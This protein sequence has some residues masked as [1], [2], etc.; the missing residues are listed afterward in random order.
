MPQ[1][2]AKTD[3]LEEMVEGPARDSLALSSPAPALR[4]A[5]EEVPPGSSAALAP[6]NSSL[7]G[8][9]AKDEMIA[10][11]KKQTESVLAQ[12]R[13]ATERFREVDRFDA[14]Q[15][16]PAPVAAS[17]AAL[18]EQARDFRAKLG[19]EVTFYECGA[20]TATAEALVTADQITRDLKEKNAP[21]GRTK[22]VAF[23][24]RYPAPTRDN[25]K[26]LWRYLGGILIASNKAR[27]DA[28]I[29]LQRAKSLEAAGKKSE[30]LRELQEIYRIYPNAI[31]ADRMKQLE[32]RIR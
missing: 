25:Q 32:A 17:V 31:T 20:E 13:D 10:D 23:F 29:H 16:L 3:R 26:P 4:N 18:A 1:P 11:F 9:K 5:L 6:P 21:A 27:T 7:I 30:A 14:V 22:L 2:G 19:Y 8:G 28:E 12:V 15:A 24:K